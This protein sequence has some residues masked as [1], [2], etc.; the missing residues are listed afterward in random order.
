M[1]GSGIKM[2]KLVKTSLLARNKQISPSSLFTHSPF[3]AFPSQPC[4][5]P[6]KGLYSFVLKLFSP[7][8]RS[9]VLALPYAFFIIPMDLLLIP[10][11]KLF[12]PVAAVE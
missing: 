10:L 11:D 12:H 8:T 9:I 5:Q 4:L 6:S 7:A 1:G 3:V 2:Y